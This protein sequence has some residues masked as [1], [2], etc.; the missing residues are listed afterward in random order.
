[1]SRAKLMTAMMVVALLL[2]ACQGNPEPPPLDGT[3]TSPS[4][5]RTTSPTV[6]APSLPPEAEGT[7]PTAAKAFVRHYV[8]LVNYAMATGDT[9]PMQAASAPNCESCGAV[10]Q[11]INDLYRAGGYLKGD[12]WKITQLRAL[13]SK[14][15]GETVV[16]A[17]VLVS[18]QDRYGS[19]RAKPEEFEGGLQAM[20]FRLGRHDSD[21]MVLEWSQTT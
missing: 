13:A 11:N 15:N 8:D 10:I 5:S 14:P 1:M 2:A 3:P 12:G 19:K 16:Q 7:S 21:W 4:P 9:G 18:P 20:T 6:A 17:G